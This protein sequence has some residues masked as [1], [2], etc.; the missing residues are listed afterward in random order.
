MNDSDEMPSEPAKTFDVIVVGSGAAG[1]SAAI[2]AARHGLNTVVVEKS[3]YWGGSSSRSGGGVWIPGNSVLR[4]EAPADTPD[5]AREYVRSI[6]GTDVDPALID[7]YLNRGSEALDFILEN[8]PLRLEWVRDYSDYYPEAPGGRSTGRSCE[9]KPFDGNKLGADLATLH[10]PY[11]KNPMN[12]V[13]KQSEY[14]WLS[15]GL[16]H[17]R[18]PVKASRVAARLLLARIRRQRLLGFGASLMGQMMLGL[19]AAGVRLELGTPLVGLVTAEDRVT[20]VRVEVDGESQIWHAEHGVVLA[21]GGFDHNAEMRQQYQ[22]APIGS[23]WTTGAATNTGDGINAA[24]EI[25]AGIGFMEDAWWGPTIPF[26]RGP[27]F[28]LSERSLPRSIIVNERAERFMNES[29]PYVEAVHRMYGG[30]NGQGEGPGENIPAW[31]VFDQKYLNRYMFCAVP[32]RS[33]LPKSWLESGTVV[34]ASTIEELAAKMGVPGDRLAATIARFNGFARS[35]TDAEFGRGTSSYDHYYGDIT[36]KPNPSLG[37]IT[38]GPFYAAKMVPGDLGTKGGVTIDSSGRALRTDGSVIE[39]LYA[40][41]N[42]S[43]PVMGHTYAG[44]GAT[45]GPAMVFGYLASLD[46]AERAGRRSA[47]AAR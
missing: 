31:L 27:W 35:G 47:V 32:P 30:E 24:L 37:E 16:R 20:G 34:R 46:I 7:Q 40:A 2:T 38:D 26:P 43:T 25:G 12:V 14:R 10:P 41:G 19:R 4:R 39:G 17:W 5:A 9:P 28:A 22:R 1:M 8:T 33:P 11:N 42:T 13:I 36:N 3:R 21:C 45:I 23:D 18:G 29:L 15:T 6:V 44:P